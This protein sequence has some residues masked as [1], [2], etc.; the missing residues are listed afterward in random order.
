MVDAHERDRYFKKYLDITYGYIRNLSNFTMI[1]EEKFEEFKQ[2]EINYIVKFS[3]QETSHFY[4]SCP[5]SYS[6]IEF[7]TISPID[8]INPIIRG[9]EYATKI[10]IEKFADAFTQNLCK[11]DYCVTFEKDSIYDM[12]NAELGLV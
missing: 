7:E 9:F 11:E 8:T 1:D 10:S 6:G 5:D 4:K 12:N 3:S 2:K